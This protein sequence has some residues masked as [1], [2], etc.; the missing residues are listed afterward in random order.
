MTANPYHIAALISNYL[1][2]T[3]TAEEAQALE[4]WIAATSENKAM[5]ETLCGEAQSEADIAFFARLDVERAWRKT[6]KPAAG[7]PVLPNWIRYAGMVSAAAMFFVLVWVWWPRIADNAADAAVIRTAQVQGNDVMPGGQRAVLVLSDGRVVDLEAGTRSVKE[8]DGTM[9]TS[10]G[11]ELT[12]V[13]PQKHSE[14]VNHKLLYNVLEVPKAGTYSLTLPDGTKVWVNAMSELKFP[15]RFGETER[16][17]SLAGEA[18]FE[19]A[20]DAQ[21]PFK[22]EVNGTVVEVLGT[23]FN[24]N[25]YDATTTTVLEGSV[26]VVHNENTA[27]LERGHQ[28]RIT[29]GIVVEPA[30]LKKAVAWKNGD[31][32]FQSDG[33]VD[34]MDQLARWYD[35][36][37]VYTGN[38]PYQKGYNGSIGRNA[39]LSEVLD[40]LSFATRSTFKIEE[41]KVTV[42]FDN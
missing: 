5:F 35:L 11:G 37:V 34:I 25:S 28:A 7:N 9:I 22:V 42:I 12:Y 4:C 2:G 15:T 21:R 29:D 19:V 40:I 6:R 26:K 17:V 16:K 13:G 18:Y 27:V 32:Y 31:F 33:I 20:H 24:I 8:Q 38:V 14:N 39:K 36:T 30:D 10:T 3:I 1:R 41:R 23:H